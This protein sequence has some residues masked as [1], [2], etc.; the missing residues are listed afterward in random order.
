MT[1]CPKYARIPARATVEAIAPPAMASQH[2]MHPPSGL[3]LSPLKPNVLSVR[4]RKLGE[5]KGDVCGHPAVAAGRRWGDVWCIAFW[6]RL[7]TCDGSA[8]L[9][10]RCQRAFWWPTSAVSASPRAT[11]AGTRPPPG[12]LDRQQARLIISGFLE[13]YNHE[14]LIDRLGHRTP[15]MA[16][17][18]VAAA[19]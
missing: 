5:P 9:L 4:L 7:R 16:R 11:I 14:W 18:E 1:L 10:L 13:R 17:A 12:E 2:L 3:G 19:A 8:A 6:S 15:A